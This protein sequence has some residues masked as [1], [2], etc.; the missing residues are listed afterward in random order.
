MSRATKPRSRALKLVSESCECRWSRK[1]GVSGGAKLRSSSSSPLPRQVAALSNDQSASGAAGASSVGALL[2]EVP[3]AGAAAS[4]SPSSASS[5]SSAGFSIRM[6]SISWLSSTVESCSSRIDCCNCGVSVRCWDSR[7]CSEGFIEFCSVPSLRLKLHAEV[8]AQID[9][10]H[11]V[12][13]NNLLRLPGGEHRALVDD[14]RTVADAERLAN[15]MIRYEH[16]DGALLEEPD[17]ALDVEHRDRVDPRV[18]AQVR[19]VQVFQELAET[20]LDRLRSKTLQLEDRLHVFLHREAAEHRILLRQVRDAEPRAAVD[21]QMR[22]LRLVEE[23][24]ARVHRHEADDHVE[25]GGLAG[26]VR[27]EQP[28]HFAAPHFERHILHHGAR[29]VTLAQPLRAQE[30]AIGGFHFAGGLG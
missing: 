19:D 21:R 8:L 9:S 20:R 22:E 4:G 7:N 29:L 17:D 25:A 15:V 12:I 18:L 23:D 1:V 30:A 11:A 6:R 13:I 10:A 28:D 3:P 14:V 5:R 27:A 2:L 24:A 16:A 26:A